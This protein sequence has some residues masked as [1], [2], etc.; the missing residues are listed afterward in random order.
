MYC[1]RHY[2]SLFNLLALGTSANE[3]RPLKHHLEPWPDKQVA[4]SVQD[5]LGIAAS[6]NARLDLGR[7]EHDSHGGTD[8][9]RRQI[10]PE[11]RP[12]DTVRAMAAADLTPHNA[13]LRSVFQRLR[14]VDVG[15]P[16]PEVE[17]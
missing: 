3:T 2:T 15:N 7:V 9:L 8:G 6:S 10:S 17:V 11:L 12:H 16:F 14:L 1:H 13:V 5:T 4:F